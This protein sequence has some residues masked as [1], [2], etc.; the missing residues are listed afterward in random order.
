[1]IKDRL[2]VY[3]GTFDPVTNGHLDIISRAT[4]VVDRLIIAVAGNAG[5][6]PLFT[7]DERLAMLNDEIANLANGDG[8][9]IE[10]R[11]FDVLLMDFMASVEAGV[12]VR[13]LRAV[14]D[15]EYEFQMAGMNARLNPDV[16]TVFLMASDRH[17]FISSRFVKEIGRLGGEVGHFVSPGVRERL[18]KRFAEGD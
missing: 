6:E 13:G 4:R 7:I 8:S 11:P 14:S 5:K 10:V 17:Q 1:M 16:E 3:P 15:F 18:L 2:G 12:I 9:P